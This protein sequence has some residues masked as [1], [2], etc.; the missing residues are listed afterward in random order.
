MKNFKKVIL[1]AGLVLAL[2]GCGGSSLQELSQEEIKE[3]GGKVTLDYV[4]EVNKLKEIYSLKNTAEVFGEDYDNLIKRKKFSH[5][6]DFWVY[7]KTNDNKI[8][9]VGINCNNYDENIKIGE[10]IPNY[11]KKDCYAFPLE[12]LEYEKVKKQ[13]ENQKK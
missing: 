13:L 11:S 4:K 7:G 12:Y 2:A 8:I 6:F 1:G 3:M 9:P 10:K 5:K